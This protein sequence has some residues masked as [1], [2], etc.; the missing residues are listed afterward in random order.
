[1]AENGD[2]ALGD[3]RERLHVHGEAIDLYAVDLTSRECAGQRIDGDVFR[4][5]V[6]CGLVELAIE[7]GRLDLAALGQ[8]AERRIRS[9]EREN[10]KT[11]VD[12]LLE[13]DAVMLGDGGKPDVYFVRAILGTDIK[14]RAW[15]GQ[16]AQPVLSGG[17]GDVLHQLDNALAGAT[18]TGK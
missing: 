6:A 3:H 1:M 15:L 10:A 16:R 12:Q 9:E 17:M 2:R 5:D 7:A 18:L 4:L 13:R 8:G 14:R 11:T